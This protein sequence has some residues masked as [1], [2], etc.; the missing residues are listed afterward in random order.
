MS[1]VGRVD[2]DEALGDVVGAHLELHVLLHGGVAGREHDEPLAGVVVELHAHVEVAVLRH[3]GL[4]ELDEVRAEALGCRRGAALPI[5]GE[6]VDRGGPVDRGEHRALVELAHGHHAE[7]LGVDVVERRAPDVVDRVGHPVAVGPRL[8]GGVLP[9]LLHVVV[10]AHVLIEEEVPDRHGVG[11]GEEHL[12]AGAAR[13][14]VHA[15]LGVAAVQPHVLGPVVHVWVDVL[16]DPGGAG[17]PEP[18]LVGPA[19]GVLRGVV[20]L[21]GGHRHGPV[22]G[23]EAARVGHHVGHLPDA[24]AVLGGGVGAR[25]AP[26]DHHHEHRVGRGSRGGPP[27]QLADLAVVGVFEPLQEVLGLGL[28][29]GAALVLHADVLAV[30]PVVEVVP[31]AGD[32]WCGQTGLG[33]RRGAGREEVGLP[34]REPGGELGPLG[35]GER[36]PVGAQLLDEAREAGAL[37][38]GHTGELPHTEVGIHT[39]EQLGADGGLRGGAGDGGCG[40]RRHTDSREHHASGATEDPQDSGARPPGGGTPLRRGTGVG[41]LG[42]AGRRTFGDRQTRGAGGGRHRLLH[43]GPVNT[44]RLSPTPAR[45][46][47]DRP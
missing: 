19:V 21:V 20:E 25:T 7:E 45:D 34:G 28:G 14:G 46:D 41:E 33:G 17:F 39:G 23:V 6:G 37:G 30:F 8:G 32:R 47:G 3:G 36:V 2:V 42:R 18:E 16:F 26:V 27:A 5:R 1:I 40:Q 10:P 13:P 29:D 31:E 15:H 35:R 44:A 22:A 11:V 43:L 38:V 9:D 24:G 12:T 4:L